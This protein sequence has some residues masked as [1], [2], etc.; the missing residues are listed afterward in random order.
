MPLQKSRFIRIM[1]TILLL[2]VGI[3]AH[4]QFYNGLNMTFGKNRVQW[5][6]FHWS[7]YRNDKFDI[8][9]YQGGQD[10]AKYAQQYAKKQIP[11]ME[12]KLGGQFGKKIQFLVFNSLS[13]FKQS[14][15]NNKEEDTRNTGG[16]TK[17]IGT[18]VILYFD[19]NYVNFETQIREGIAQLLMSQ[20]MN[21]MR[22]SFTREVVI[23]PNAV[24]MM[25]PI[26]ISRTLPRLMNAL[27]SA[28]SPGFFS[29]AIYNDLQLM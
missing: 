25:T 2:S 12:N 21:G 22:M 4:A 24:A 13:D 10:L 5:D 9:Y 14:N 17:I 11:A 23:L 20:L 27:N 7:Y 29:F 1:L 3:G 16:V 28:M 6:D 8:Y 19:G 18:K 26:A 15:I